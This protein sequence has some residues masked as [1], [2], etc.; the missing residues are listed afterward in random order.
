MA[1]SSWTGDWIKLSSP[2]TF[3]RCNSIQHRPSPT[4][5]RSKIGQYRAELLEAYCAGFPNVFSFS[6]CLRQRNIK[7]FQNDIHRIN[8]I[9][10]YVSG[11]DISLILNARGVLLEFL[12][13][14]ELIGSQV[15]TLFQ[16][17]TCHFPHP[18]SGQIS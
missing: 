12:G 16:T 3:P 11:L 13:G 18:F 6:L 5:N 1:V 4:P 15:L 14:G 8:E 10:T 7:W 9:D 2:K 17:R